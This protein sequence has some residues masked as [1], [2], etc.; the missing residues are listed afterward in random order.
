MKKFIRL[1]ILFGIGALLLLSCAKLAY[2][3]Q[4]TS[5]MNKTGAALFFQTTP[6]PKVEEDKSVVGSTDG[7]VI[8]GGIITLIVIIPILARRKA[9]MRNS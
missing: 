7:I 2:S 1:F 9:W 6:T 3:I 8:M 4:P 5:F